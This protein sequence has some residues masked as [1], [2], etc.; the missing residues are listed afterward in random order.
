MT[1]QNITFPLVGAATC[2]DK[3]P[4]RQQVSFKDSLI[5]S[6]Q[7]AG[8]VQQ[9]SELHNHKNLIHYAQIHP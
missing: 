7:T 1:L 2:T 3:G 5:D 9:S 4:R 8:A 6:Q